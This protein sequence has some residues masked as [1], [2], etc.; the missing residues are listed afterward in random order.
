MTPQPTYSF[1]HDNRPLRVVLRAGAAATLASEL[2]RLGT[3]RAL[4]VT[5]PGRAAMARGMAGA[6]DRV[7]GIFADARLHVPV[8]VVDAATAQAERLAADTLVAL[9]GG[10]AIGVAKAVALRTD[11]PILALPTTYAGSEMTSIWGTTA[12]DEKRTGRDDR[13][14]PRV[15]IYDPLLTPD[16]SQS[17]SAES[18]MNAIAHCVEALYAPNADPF[19]SLIAEEGIRVMAHS[20][21]HILREPRDVEARTAAL[22]AAHLGGRALDMTAM[23]LQH[24]V[25]HILGGMFGLPHA[26]T[27]AIMLPH[28]VAFNAPAAPR[29]MAAITRALV[30]HDIDASDAARSLH[31]LNQDLGIHA[32]LGDLGLGDPEIERAAARLVGAGVTHPRPVTL[33]SAGRLLRDAQSGMMPGAG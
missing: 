18:G 26:L 25:C 21:R 13:V 29:A 11:L 5:T 14:A 33:A 10:S 19:T 31:A 6:L 20:L 2:S 7:A 9:G 22:Y 32:T 12:G 17:A 8:A 28:V 16:L 1:E 15:V 27:H 24:K 3:Q 4:F 30:E 23:G